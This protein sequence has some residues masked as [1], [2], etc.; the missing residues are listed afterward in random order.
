MCAA[1]SGVTSQDGQSNAS[2]ESVVRRSSRGC[3]GDTSQDGRSNATFKSV[4]CWS[5]SDGGGDEEDAAA[6]SRLPAVVEN[7]PAR[8]QAQLRSARSD[9]AFLQTQHKLTLRG[10][11]AEVA[12]LQKTVKEMQFA[13]FNNGMTLVDEASYQEKIA[14]LEEDLDKWC[15]HCR[16]LSSQLEQAN[17]AL[18]SLNQRLQVQEWQHQAELSEKNSIIANLQREL[19]WKC[20]TLAELEMFT[21]GRGG[22][23]RMSGPAGPLAASMTSS[24]SLVE[25]CELTR[26]PSQ[27]SLPAGAS[28]KAASTSARKSSHRLPVIVRDRPAN[29]DDDDDIVAQSSLSSGTTS[30]SVTPRRHHT[31]ARAASAKCLPVTVASSSFSASSSGSKMKS[32]QAGARGTVETDRRRAQLRLPPLVDP[33][34]ALAFPARSLVHHQLTAVHCDSGLSTDEELSIDRV[35]S[36]ELKPKKMGGRVVEVSTK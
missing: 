15:C 5:S 14:Q 12:K 32:D 2:F 35:P 1:P 4:A 19:E 30:R 9:L 26:T 6:S 24:S 8:L 31:G 16:F 22:T 27:R 28:G 25:P 7:D 17:N 36:P 29:D 10:L 21:R 34:R 18:V 11:H 33:T 3:G 13:L 20:R 23:R